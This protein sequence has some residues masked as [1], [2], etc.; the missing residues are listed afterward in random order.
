M[1]RDKV[2]VFLNSI[3]GTEVDG[4]DELF[5][6]LI[7]SAGEYISSV[8]S[9]EAGI[10]CGRLTKGSNEYRE[11]ISSLN[12]KKDKCHNSLVNNIKIINR[13]L[14]NLNFPLIFEGNEENKCEVE[15]F[16]L[17]IVREFA[18]LDAKEASVS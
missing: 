6:D 5:E 16:A 7:V 9:L 8:I 13:S 10:V 14:K 4:I 11:Y 3:N 18:K 15:K 2:T 1:I 12:I 17:T